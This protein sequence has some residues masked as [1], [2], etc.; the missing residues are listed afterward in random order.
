MF[1]LHCLYSNNQRH[2]RAGR[3]Q[4]ISELTSLRVDG[5]WDRGEAINPEGSVTIERLNCPARSKAGN[6]YSVGLFVLLGVSK[7]LET[8]YVVLLLVGVGSLCWALWVELRLECDTFS[9]CL[10]RYWCV[11]ISLLCRLVI[12]LGDCIGCLGRAPLMAL[13]GAVWLLGVCISLRGLY[14]CIGGSICT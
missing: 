1:P 10:V 11:S 7:G 14:V 5:F 9:P 8:S 6:E 13:G 3:N 2:T 4:C 12:S